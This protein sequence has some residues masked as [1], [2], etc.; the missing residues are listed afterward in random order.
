MARNEGVTSAA[1]MVLAFV[2]S[3][4]HTIHMLLLAAGVGTAGVGFLT[5]TYIR[6]FMLT[7]AVAM[8]GWTLYKVFRKRQPPA[9]RV[10][11]TVSAVISLGLVLFSLVGGGLGG[12]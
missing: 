2:G 3:Q 5:N 12:H 11:G 4:H 8:S 7:M 10:L 9:M 1:S 6:A